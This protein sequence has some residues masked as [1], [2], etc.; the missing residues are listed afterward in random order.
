[1]PYI[2]PRDYTHAAVTPETPGELNFTITMDIIALLRKDISFQD[3]TLDV[4]TLVNEHIERVGMSYT[5]GNAV[6]GVLDCAAREAWRRVHRDSRDQRER[7]AFVISQLRMERDRVY[8]TILT[9]YENQKIA[10]NGDVYPKELL[11]EIDG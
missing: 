11:Q 3:F 7:L 9:P 8:N 1:M 5:T 6:M 2:D 4:Q 10:E